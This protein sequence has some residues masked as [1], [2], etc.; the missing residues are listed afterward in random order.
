MSE[1]GMGEGGR[2]GSRGCPG[3]KG[4]AQ[5]QYKALAHACCRVLCPA[6]NWRGGQSYSHFS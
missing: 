4:R 5:L 3:L 6:W 1:E 2:L